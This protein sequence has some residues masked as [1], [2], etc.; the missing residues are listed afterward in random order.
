MNYKRYFNNLV[1]LYIFCLTNSSI[2]PQFRSSR[3]DIS[4]ISLKSPLKVIKDLP[5]V[6]KKLINNKNNKISS[7]K[8]SKKE[9]FKELTLL[10][11]KLFNKKQEILP[12]WI[13]SLN[14]GFILILITSDLKD[15]ENL[16]K[17]NSQGFLYFFFLNIIN[18]LLVFFIIK[19]LYYNIVISFLSPLIIFYFNYRLT[20]NLKDFSYINKNNLLLF[21]IGFLYNFIHLQI[22]SK[23]TILINKISREKLEKEEKIIKELIQSNNSQLYLV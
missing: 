20:K 13:L 5:P 6:S 12:Y 14:I 1:G 19:N 2:N 18:N 3:S 7:Q 8:N 11:E 21:T 15:I 9:S 10:K 17:I 23:K 4:L 22:L 16:L